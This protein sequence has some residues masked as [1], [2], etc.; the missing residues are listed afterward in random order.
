MT[1]QTA[2]DELVK[3]LRILAEQFNTAALGEAAE[4]ITRLTEELSDMTSDYFRRHKEVGDLF[5]QNIELRQQLLETLAAGEGVSR[6]DAYLVPSLITF[7]DARYTS[8]PEQY[9]AE[10][11]GSVGWSASLLCEETVVIDKHGIRHDTKPLFARATPSPTILADLVAEVR[12]KA[13]EEAAA[14][15]TDDEETWQ[16]PAESIRRMAAE[17]KGTV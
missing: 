13:L 5:E 9:Q 7:K 3:L 15:F 10:I 17:V 12:R 16:F 4:R 11:G 6:P 1:L 14:L 2:D 8:C